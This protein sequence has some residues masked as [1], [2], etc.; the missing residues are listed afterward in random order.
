MTGGI[1]I[2]ESSSAGRIML[3]VKLAAACY[4]CAHA[5]TGAE[6]LRLAR[7]LR[8][9][10]ILVDAALPDMEGAALCA[11]MAADPATATIPAILL[12]PP[13]AEGLRVRALAAGAADVQAKPV[14]ETLLLARLRSLARA[15]ADGLG[16]GAAAAA[17]SG[18]AEGPAD[19]AGGAAPGRDDTAPGRLA[20]VAGQP[21]R[22]LAWRRAL[23]GPLGRAPEVM[24]REQVLADAGREVEL[25]V[26][27]ADLARPGEGLQLAS[28]L[29]SRPATCHAAVC[30]VLPPA[31]GPVPAETVAA[32]ALDLGAA[33]VLADPFPP[34][35][36]ALR[37]LAQLRRK[38]AADRLRAG[39]RAGLRMAVI[40]PLVGVYNRRYALHRLDL[41]AARAA[42]TGRGLAVLLL[43]LDRF[44]A[45]NDSHG[46]A[47]GDAVLVAVAARLRAA[48]RPADLFARI[49]GEEFLVALPDTAP[50]PGLAVAEA[51]RR[52]VVSSPVLLPEGA[53]AVAVTVSIGM[54]WLGGEARAAG[55]AGARA[56]QRADDA[57]LTAKRRGRNQV[58]PGLAPA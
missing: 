54:A 33:E 37:I 25:Y 58:V 43:D 42:E 53:G 57:L 22:A 18:L 50:G 56:L 5:A 28:E 21:A 31:D 3:K 51:L 49:G 11:R 2:V 35:E 16:A 34:E 38:R 20:I 12:V 14:N 39:V 46:H 19:W 8:P 17:E 7:Q 55:D 30:I 29:L 27:G 52:A 6:A 41:L 40:D 23:A 36:A 32:T 9:D 1:L 45:V 24:T 13:G 44:K 26:I 48:L 15:R 4:A 47:A 10:A